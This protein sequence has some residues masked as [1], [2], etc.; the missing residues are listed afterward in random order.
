MLIKCSKIH[1]VKHVKQMVDTLIP[2]AT[3]FQQ[4]Y[5]DLFT[6]FL[7]FDTVVGRIPLWPGIFFKPARC[8][9]T[10]TT[11]VTY[12]NITQ[13]SYS[14][15]YITPTQQI[16]SN[17]NYKHNVLSFKDFICAPC[18]YVNVI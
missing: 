4:I 10:L 8:G 9:Y 16:S 1:T 3:N 11:Y 6:S 17:Y 15:E 14:P 5:M 7:T 12:S 18:I 13:A 2:T